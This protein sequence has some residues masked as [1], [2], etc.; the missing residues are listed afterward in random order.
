MKK[1]QLFAAALMFSVAASSV[2]TGVGAGMYYAQAEEIV[3]GSGAALTGTAMPTNPTPMPNGPGASLQ[4]SQV[5]TAAEAAAQNLTPQMLKVVNVGE[6]ASNF[7]DK[8][9]SQSIVKTVSPYTYDYMVNDLNALQQ[10]YPSYM[11]YRSLGKTADGRDIWDCVI[12]NPN[13]PKQ[14]LIQAGMHAR[15]HINSLLMMQEI[16]YI[17]ENYETGYWDGLNLRDMFEQVQL[18]I[19]PMVNPDGVTISQL[20]LEG[21]K[22]QDLRDKVY[23]IWQEDVKDGYASSN[24][25]TALSRWKNNAEGVDIN[26]NFDSNW[27]DGTDKVTRPSSVYYKGTAPASEPEAAALVNLINSYSNW[28]FTISVHSTGSLIYIDTKGNQVYG[29]SAGFAWNLHELSGYQITGDVSSGR[30]FKDWCQSKSN[31]IPSVTVETGKRA[32]PD[33]FAEYESIWKKNKFLWLYELRY[34]YE[35]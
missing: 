7:T 8:D 34:A 13:A 24:L 18:H 10:K 11:T 9:S 17:L 2:F 14:I 1:R 20:G 28:K 30:G 16:E 35:H 4:E 26:Q 21:L 15:E 32:C 3:V 31:P 12:G 5:K 23:S 29:A 6:G 22:R 27:Y 19:V 25:A 33:N